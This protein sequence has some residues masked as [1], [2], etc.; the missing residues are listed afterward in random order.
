MNYRTINKSNT[1][2]SW[3]KIKA[4]HINKFACEFN[5][6]E[7]LQKLISISNYIFNDD[8]YLFDETESI[9]DIYTSKE[10][11]NYKS[12]TDL[13]LIESRRTFL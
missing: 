4:S 10:S 1:F 13:R 6:K 2:L 3:L 11:Y 12:N 9:K 5:F 8:P 7:I